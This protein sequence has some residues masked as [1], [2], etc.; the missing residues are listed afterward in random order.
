MKHILV[1]DSHDSFVYNLVEL[2]R[3]IEGCSFEVCATEACLQK[4]LA[5]YGGIL[6]SPGP[7][8]VTEVE[9]LL[10][11]I[12]ACQNTHAIL[13]VCLGHQ[14]LALHY[15]AQLQ[16]L[17][18]PLHGHGEQLRCTAPEGYLTL[19]ESLPQEPIV[20]RYH[21]WVV[22]PNRLPQELV[23]TAT[24]ETDGAIMAFRHRELPHFGVQF[25]PESYLTT[26]GETIVRT[27]VNLC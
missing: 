15:G 9:G 12:A 27:W 6:L 13:G 7:G 10:P 16:Q 3:H 2:L 8:H 23:V 19:L 18:Q 11:L 24:A 20:A 17:P 5:R 14:A 26:A 21:S 4:P 1:A 22:D 25:H